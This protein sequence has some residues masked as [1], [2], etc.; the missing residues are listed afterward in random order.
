MQSI[1]LEEIM[2]FNLGR[3]S[4]RI[5]EDEQTYSQDDFERDLHDVSYETEEGC[6][7]VNLIKSKAAPYSHN[8][9]EK[10]I[11]SNFLIC[12]FDP[13]VLDPWYFCYQ[14][15]ESRGV[16]QQISMFHQGTTL[17]VKR[18][19]VITI[20]SLRIRLPDIDKQRT[21]GNLYK[22]TIQRNDLLLRLAEESKQ[23]TKQLIEKIE[24]A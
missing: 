10:V 2:Q 19:N 24:E 6:C 14:F 22:V 18:L 15:N 11:T 7:I 3:N 16:E 17:S 9:T 4:T 12:T 20:G 1:T 21:I 23:F 13:D 5:R 8:R